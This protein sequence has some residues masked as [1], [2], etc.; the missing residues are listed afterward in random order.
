MIVQGHC[1]SQDVTD[2]PWVYSP[3]ES[4]LDT[5]VWG[6]DILAANGLVASWPAASTPWPAC[7]KH[8]RYNTI[9]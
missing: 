2:L 9:L 3:S 5:D 7:G 6:T 8:I 4:E 1:I